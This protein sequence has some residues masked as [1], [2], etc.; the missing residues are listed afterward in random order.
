VGKK[1]KSRNSSL[2]PLEEGLEW[3]YQR[4]LIISEQFDPVLDTLR[5]SNKGRKEIQNNETQY[6]SY[7]RRSS[8]GTDYYHIKTDAG[9]ERVAKRT[10]VEIK[11]RFDL[12]SRMVMPKRETLRVGHKWTVET[13]PYVLRARPGYSASMAENIIK[14]TSWGAR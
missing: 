3:G 13:I 8:D 9:V 2:F 14:M 6:T 7:V 11:P 1:M 4:S 10:V 12:S 5:L